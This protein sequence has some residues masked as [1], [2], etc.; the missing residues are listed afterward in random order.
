MGEVEASCR[1]PRRGEFDARTKR[2][3]FLRDAE[4][5]LAERHGNPSPEDWRRIAQAAKWELFLY[6]YD[7]KVVRGSHLTDVEARA[8][9]VFALARG[10]ALRELGI[11]ADS[12]AETAA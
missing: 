1:P 2:G 11:D 3:R 9:E 7:Q 5:R 6:L 12:R 8:Y 4:T 10:R